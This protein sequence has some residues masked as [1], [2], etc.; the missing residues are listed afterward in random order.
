MS[1]KKSPYSGFLNKFGDALKAD[2]IGELRE[3]PLTIRAVA[4]RTG[5]SWVT[6]NK[7]L[8]ELVADGTVELR[9]IEGH[10]KLFSISPEFERGKRP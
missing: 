2:I 1:K 3:G 10:T 9:E 8:H 7:R 6:A 4:I 5:L